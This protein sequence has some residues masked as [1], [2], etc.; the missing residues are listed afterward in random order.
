MLTLRHI[1]SG[2][3]WT[4]TSRLMRSIYGRHGVKS[5]SWAWSVSEK[6]T[7]GMP[8]AHPSNTAPIVPEYTTLM[9]ALEPWLMPAATIAGRRPPSTTCMASLMQSTGVPFT[10][11]IFAPMKSGSSVI[12]SGSLTVMAIDCPERGPSGHTATTSPYGSRRLMSSCTPGASYPSSFD[13]R[14]RGLLSLFI[15]CLCFICVAVMASV[16]RGV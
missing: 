15:F 8:K 6:P 7:E 11:Y 5:A 3:P 1:P 10:L 14:M 9:A 16:C 12:R 2:S 4:S 13:T